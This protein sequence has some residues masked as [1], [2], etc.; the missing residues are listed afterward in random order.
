[1][2]TFRIIF[3]FLPHSLVSVLID[4]TPP[5]TSV[6]STKNRFTKRHYLCDIAGLGPRLQRLQRKE[7]SYSSCKRLADN[8]IMILFY[9]EVFLRF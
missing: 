7:A 3:G 8:T 5:N 4:S 6:N 9:W 1:M 2:M